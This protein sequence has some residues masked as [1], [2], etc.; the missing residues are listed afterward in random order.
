[1][2]V[3]GIEGYLLG[4]SDRESCDRN[5]HPHFDMHCGLRDCGVPDVAELTMLFIGRVLMPVSGSL[6]GKKTDGQN[7]DYRQ[8]SY[9][10]PLGHCETYGTPA[11][12]DTSDA[13]PDLN[14]SK[15]IS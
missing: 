4:L 1:M 12:H 8:Q 3:D 6:N 15:V 2:T 10:Y 13:V 5:G 7:E 14:V 9:R 11:E